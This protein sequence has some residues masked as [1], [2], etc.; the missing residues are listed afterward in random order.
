[1]IIRPEHRNT[2]PRAR[3]AETLLMFMRQRGG[4]H[5]AVN[6]AL[7]YVPLADFYDL[8]DGDRRLSK[9]DYYLDEPKQGLAWEGEVNLAVKELKKD[10]YLTTSA[11]AGKSIWRLTPA[12]VE[13][14]DFW[15][16]RM[17]EKRS[18]LG[19]LKVDSE[20]AFLDFDEPQA[21]SLG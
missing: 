10:G 14:A 5:A 17:T 3:I 9:S 21:V 20:L 16:K 2:F 11:R 4:A 13:R 8:S 1:M 12:G 15:L 19:S 7:V 6:S 18:A